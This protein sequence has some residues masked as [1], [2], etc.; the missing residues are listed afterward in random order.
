[1]RD[2]WYNAALDFVNEV[3]GKRGQTPLNSL[4]KGFKSAAWCPVSMSIKE[5]DS[6]MVFTVPTFASKFGTTRFIGKVEINTYDDNDDS[7][8]TQE[9][10]E[11]PIDVSHFVNRF[12]SGYYKDLEYDP[13]DYA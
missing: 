3:R 9:T 13:E 2:R 6:E 11:L 12:D 10:Y 7:L 4:R 8:F 1:M 5:R